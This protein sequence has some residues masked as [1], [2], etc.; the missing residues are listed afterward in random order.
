MTKQEGRYRAGGSHGLTAV[1]DETVERQGNSNERAPV[2][3]EVAG[4][5]L[6]SVANEELFARLVVSSRPQHHR[7][8]PE[9]ARCPAFP[10]AKNR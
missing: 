5:P 9:Q 8:R 2:L 6:W 4:R 10:C 7:R 3:F 1:A